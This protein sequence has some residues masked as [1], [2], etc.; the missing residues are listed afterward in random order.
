MF[1]TKI[2]W[3]GD[4]EFNKN[5]KVF[6]SFGLGTYIQANGLTQSGGIVESIW[7]KTL[8]KIKHQP[9]TINHCLILG[10]G[11]G[12]VAKIIRK[13]WPDSKITGV[14]IDPVMIELGKKYLDLD[15]YKVDIKIQDARK[16]AFKNYD[17]IIVDTYIGDKFI[18]LKGSD[19]LRLKIWIFNRLYYSSKKAEAEMFGKKLEK[20]FSK[21]ERF[22]PPA[23]LMY[24]CYNNMHV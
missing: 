16:F 2:L 5:I 12:S 7:N 1:L 22:Y 13:Y 11:G 15:K 14:E 10:L 21:V 20:I 9:L 4:S 19:L 24:I 8:N 17:L 18:N 23:N 6:K 3:E